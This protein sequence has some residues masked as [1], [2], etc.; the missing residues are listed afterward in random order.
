MCVD[1]ALFGDVC[2]WVFVVLCLVCC[3]GCE[4]LVGCCLLFVVWCWDWCLLLLVEC[5]M[6]VVVCWLV[7]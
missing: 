2:C 5:V 4:L 1:A 7:C 6:C 3:V